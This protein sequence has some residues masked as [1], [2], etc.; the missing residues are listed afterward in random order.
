MPGPENTGVIHDIGYQRYDGPRLGRGYASRSLYVHSV[1]GAYGLGRSAWAKVLP[2]GLASLACMAALVL[3]VVNTQLPVQ[4]IDYVGIASTFTYAATVFVAVV[5]PELVS[6]DLRG[7]VLSLYL[8]RPLRRSDYALTKLAALATS[9]FAMLAAPML[10]LF[11][12]MAFSTDDGFSG[13]LGELGG[14][15]Q[16]LVAGA[17]HAV[18][19]A[20]LALPFAALSGRRVFATGMI[21]AVSLLTAPVSGVLMEFGTG[22]AAYLAGLINPVN[23]V[24]G[25]DRWLFDGGTVDPGPYGPVYGLVALAI[26]AIGT[27][28]TVWRYKGVKA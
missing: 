24:N 21:V 22:D 18:V 7:N 6:S 15:A 16:G 19:L 3:V 23:L 25:I 28:C 9:V 26:V 14:L 20:A 8:S 2:F 27:A 10:I 12:G 11:L 17:I 1:R 4:V 5:A 13:V